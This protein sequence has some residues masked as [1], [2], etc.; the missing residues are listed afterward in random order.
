MDGKVW[1]ELDCQND[2]DALEAGA[3]GTFKISRLKEIRMIRL[4]QTGPNHFGG[5]HLIIS[6]FEIFGWLLEQKLFPQHH[7]LRLSQMMATLQHS[8]SPGAVRYFGGSSCLWIP[9][10][11]KLIETLKI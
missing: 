5:H 2:N 10:R 6:A 8:R 4:M 11:M 9:L 1:I 3:V 7:L